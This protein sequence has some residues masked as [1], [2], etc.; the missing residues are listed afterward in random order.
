MRLARSYLS[1]GLSQRIYKQVSPIWGM[2]READ[3]KFTSGLVGVSSSPPDDGLTAY[4]EFRP[5]T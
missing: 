3:L 2:M 4:L 5:L 1:D